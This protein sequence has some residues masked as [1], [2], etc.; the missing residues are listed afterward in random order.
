M[1]V[2]RHT[3]TTWYQQVI[4]SRDIKNLVIK[5]PSGNAATVFYAVSDAP[6]ADKEYPIE[7]GDFLNL[8]FDSTSPTKIFVKWNAWD[9]LHLLYW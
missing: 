9:F 3:V 7:S 5:A 4:I 6:T 1:Q 2:S 8:N